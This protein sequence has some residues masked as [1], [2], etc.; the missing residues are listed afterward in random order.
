M[1]III[2]TIF[3][4][5]IGFIYIICVHYTKWGIGMN[6]PFHKENYNKFHFSEINM[7]SR[8]V[9]CISLLFWGC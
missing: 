2:I 1:Y 5:N 8:H 6:T 9:I 4:C 3:T 7:T